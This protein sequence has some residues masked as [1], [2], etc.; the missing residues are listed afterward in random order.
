MFEDAANEL[1][2]IDPESRALP[3]VIDF[4]YTIYAAMGQWSLAEV[5]ASH[6]AG[7]FP[8]EPAGWIRWAYATRRCRSIEEARKILLDAERQNPK[9]GAIQFNLGC[10]ACQE[11]DHEEAKRRV[12]AAI[13]RSGEF[14]W[15]ALHD[16][17]LKPL[18]DEIAEGR[19]A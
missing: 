14:R 19:P 1:E 2:G 17:D 10:Y 12:S 3:E 11:G 9:D 8:K 4:R 13:A 7:L 18:W 6:M 16:P 5:V 15:A